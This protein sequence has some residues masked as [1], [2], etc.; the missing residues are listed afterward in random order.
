MSYIP[1]RETDMEADDY[2]MVAD[3]CTEWGRSTD[4]AAESQNGFLMKQGIGTG[5]CSAGS[6]G[7]ELRSEQSAS[8]GF[9][10]E[11]ATRTQAQTEKQLGVGS[12]WG[13]N[14]MQLS[15]WKEMTVKRYAGSHRGNALSYQGMEIELTLRLYL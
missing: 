8:K 5:L 6:E 14:C 13:I 11:V 4:S 7:R 15:C 12:V 3:S 1:A 9:Q 10:E 2:K